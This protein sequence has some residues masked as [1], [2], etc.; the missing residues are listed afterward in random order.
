MGAIKYLYLFFFNV[1]LLNSNAQN[2]VLN[3]SFENYREL[4]YL[5]TTLD[6][7]F[8]KGWYVPSESSPDYYHKNSGIPDLG[9]PY[10]LFGKHPAKTG[11]A[12]IGIIPI[13]WDGYMEHITGTLKTSLEKGENYIISFNIRFAG[14]TCFFFASN[15][16]VYFS[17]TR[18]PLNGYS[19]PFYD[20]LLLPEIVSN[21]KEESFVKDTGWYEIRRNYTANGSEKY[22]TI[23]IFY[24]VD[25]NMENK[26]E[27]FIQLK[28]NSKNRQKFYEKNQNILQINPN[29]K[30][31]PSFGD[32][33]P[34]YFI[35]DVTIEK[36]TLI[37]KNKFSQ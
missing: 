19:I 8:C 30:M 36:D 27:H 10:N 5:Y 21:I 4:P 31:N 14:N 20:E 6:S 33:V 1:L 28:L 2:L 35:D 24:E 32:E 3:P 29:Y 17:D 18:F 37:T 12:Y 22:F 23:G 16:G 25:W 26:T 11:D 9:I 7:F 34:Y 13:V 15:I